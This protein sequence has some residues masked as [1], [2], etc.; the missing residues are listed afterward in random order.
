M[1]FN[2]KTAHVLTIDS[3]YFVFSYVSAMWLYMLGFYS[4]TLSR[5]VLVLEGMMH[6][7]ND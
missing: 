7:K 4:A 1:G 2:Q 6:Y 3:N 5:Y